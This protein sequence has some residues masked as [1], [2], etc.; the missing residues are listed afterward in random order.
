SL[1]YLYCSRVYILPGRLRRAAPE[2]CVCAQRS[3]A[4]RRGKSR[5]RPR[6][7]LRLGSGVPCLER[8]CLCLDA[9]PLGTSARRPSRLGPRTLGPH[10]PWLVLGGRALEIESVVGSQSQVVGTFA[11]NLA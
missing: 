9:R 7:R 8:Q 1:R 4:S 11:L 5:G 2:R 10:T 3:A 6:A